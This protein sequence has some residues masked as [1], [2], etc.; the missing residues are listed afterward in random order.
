MIPD[1]LCIYNIRAR[2]RGCGCVHVNV[3]TRMQ[4]RAHA[5]VSCALAC[6]HWVTRLQK[7]ILPI[8]LF[9]GKILAFCVVY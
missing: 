5:R 2:V 6:A 4:V 7:K 1:D 3:R 9:S 8:R